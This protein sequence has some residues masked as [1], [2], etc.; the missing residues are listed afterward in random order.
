MNTNQ[1][2]FIILL[3][4]LAILCISQLLHVAM[5]RFRAKAAPKAKTPRPLK[6]KTADDCPFC[7]AEK[8]QRDDPQPKQAPKPWREVKSHRG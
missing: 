5:V 6:P 1:H 7:R 4:L 2:L 8:D 3:R